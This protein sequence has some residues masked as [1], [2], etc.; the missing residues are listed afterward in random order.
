[1][2]GAKLELTSEIKKPNCIISQIERRLVEDALLDPN[3]VL[4]IKEELA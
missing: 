2:K 1:M 4:V 3:R